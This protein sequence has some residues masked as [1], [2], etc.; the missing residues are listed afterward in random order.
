MSSTSSLKKVNSYK[1]SKEVPVCIAHDRKSQNKKY[2]IILSPSQWVEAILQEI[3][4]CFV[5]NV[6]GKRAEI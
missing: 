1:H 2:L 4:K 6:I 5:K 3:S